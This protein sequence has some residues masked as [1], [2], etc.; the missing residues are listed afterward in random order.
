MFA[1]PIFSLQIQTAVYSN[2]PPVKNSTKHS[3]L[4]TLHVEVVI[5]LI[6]ISRASNVWLLAILKDQ[7]SRAL[8]LSVLLNASQVKKINQELVQLVLVIFLLILFLNIF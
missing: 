3:K 8:E 2:A 6:R 5:L 7:L 1:A 4:V